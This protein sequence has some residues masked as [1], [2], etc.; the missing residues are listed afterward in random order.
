M[1]KALD[2]N[3]SDF[4]DVVILEAETMAAAIERF[5][6]ESETLNH[7]AYRIGGMRFYITG[8]DSIALGCKP[9]RLSYEEEDKIRKVVQTALNELGFELWT[10]VTLWQDENLTM[11]TRCVYD[12][13]RAAMQLK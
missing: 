10:G 7:N 3:A 8:E 1:I 11:V 6:S 2:H 9:G 5:K 13:R 12:P 4:K